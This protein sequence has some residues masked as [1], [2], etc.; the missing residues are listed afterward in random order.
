MQQTKL[1]LGT[2]CNTDMSNEDQIVLFKEMGFDGFFVDWN[3]EMDVKKLR[4]VA[5]SCGMI[6]QSIHAPFYKIADGLWQ[7]GVAAETAIETLIACAK[8][9]AENRVPIMVCHTYIGFERDDVSITPEGIENYR[10]VVEKAKELG[11]KVAFENTEG[12][13]YLAALMDAFKDYDNVGFCWDTGHEIC[14]N[15]SKD[16]MALYGDRLF[17]THL[18][19]N[20]GI[21]DFDGRITWADDLHLLPFDGVADWQDIVH[22]LNRHHYHGELTFEV[23]KHNKPGRHENDV[24]VKMPMEEYV[25]EAFKRACRVA[26]LKLRDKERV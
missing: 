26:M 25:C 1:C 20:L 22:R 6:F 12:E 17:C 24:Y 14:Y 4:E 15:H 10:K 7:G 19:D 18:E 3:K 2:L 5:D 9:C 16:M 21:R 23:N 8:D 11:V 13:E